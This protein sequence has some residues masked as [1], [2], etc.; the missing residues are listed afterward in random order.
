MKEN[1]LKPCPFSGGEALIRYQIGRAYISPIHNKDCLIEPNTWLQS[2]YPLSKQIKAWNRRAD[3]E[4]R[5]AD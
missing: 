4:Q 3:D 5:E 1:E 2:D